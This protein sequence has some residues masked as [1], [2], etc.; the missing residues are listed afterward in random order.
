MPVAG[1]QALVRR[2]GVSTGITTEPL[3]L[4]PSGQSVQFRITDS[5]K[6]VIDPN[7]DFHFKN[8]TSSIAYS[9]ITSLDLLHGYVTFSAAQ[10]AGSVTSLSFSGSYLPLTTSS[11]VFLDSKSFKLSL[12]RD[13]LDTTVFTGDSSSFTKRRL[14]AL[15]DAS[16]DIESVADV[17]Q[18]GVL[19]NSAAFAGDHVVVEVSFG[20]TAASNPKFRGITRVSDIDISG[21]NEDLVKT[22]VSFKI[23]QA[24]TLPAG[25]SAAYGFGIQP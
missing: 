5:A 2:S 21:A 9:T 3:Q 23:S 20:G 22:S 10:S 13:L 14:A 17:G 4:S 11:E 7:V 8:G 24:P 1:Y 25:F 6:R 15:K 18:L 16:L 19:T 12:S